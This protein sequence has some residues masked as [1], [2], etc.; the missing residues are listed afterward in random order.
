MRSVRFLA[1]VM[2]FFVFSS[3]GENKDK[4]TTETTSTDTSA[5]TT[6]DAPASTIV[7]TPQHMM[8]VK[9]RVAN[10]EKFLS[11][12]EAHDS[13][14]E[15]NGV[16]KYVIGRQ[17]GD[18]NMVFVSVKAD[19]MDKAMAFA[20]NPELKKAMQ[21][22]EVTGTPEM[23]FVTIVW[24]DTLQVSSNIRALSTF[25]VKDWKAWE[26]G[27]QAGKQERIDNG[28]ADRVYGYDAASNN[29]VTL[30]TA[31]MDSAKAYAY[32]KSDMLK[33]RRAQGGVIG[34]PNRFLF[35][36]TKRY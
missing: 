14:R 34:E 30:V 11:A 17:V 26:A 36:V 18:P 29:K 25:S 35:N 7:T 31:I 16:H 19:D 12:F 2:V 5:A 3:C 33:Q 13:L 1:F 15:A 21:K 9:H 6:T 28:I 23:S 4:T 10:Y 20:K 24:Q 22:S 32:W 27:F 8:L